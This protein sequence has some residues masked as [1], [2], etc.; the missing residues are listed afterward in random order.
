MKESFSVQL[1]HVKELVYYLGLTVTFL[2][3]ICTLGGRDQHKKLKLVRK[4]SG[5]TWK[6]GFIYIREILAS[7]NVINT[8]SKSIT[9]SKHQ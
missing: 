2:Y 6:Q 1:L 8:F 4:F 3:K 5:V 9:I 7:Y